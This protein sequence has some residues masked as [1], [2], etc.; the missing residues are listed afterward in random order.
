MFTGIVEDMGLVEAVEKKR[1]LCTFSLYAPKVFKGVKLGDSIAIDGVCLTVAKIKGKVLSF[2]MMKETLEKTT[3]G[4]L[5]NGSRVNLE[6]A[7]M[8]QDRFGGH[9]VTGH[10]DGLGKILKVIRDKNY[11]EFQIAMPS[12]LRKFIAPKGSICVN[13]ISLTVGATRRV[14]RTLCF[15]VYMIPFTMQVTNM[16]EKKVGDFVNIEV[17]ILARYIL[18]QRVKEL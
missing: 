12:G 1:N 6:R 4:S 13:G 7:M 3:L 10:V 9:M 2:D 5:R 18:R 16:S 15:S 14:A 11:V 17:D 8:A